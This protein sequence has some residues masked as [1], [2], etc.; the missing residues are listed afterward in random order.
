MTDHRVI[1][2]CSPA[3]APGFR[4]AGVDVHA[5]ESAADLDAAWATAPHESP[6]GLVLIEQSLLDALTREQRQ[7]LSR[8]SLPVLVPF[9]GAAWRSEA[10]S[11]EAYIAEILRQAIGYRVRLS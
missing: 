8:Q 9:P 3:L 7:Q 10:E 5:A 2:I 6:A 11:A 1:A 4:L